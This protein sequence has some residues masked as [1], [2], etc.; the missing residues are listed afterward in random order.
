MGCESWHCTKKKTGC[1]GK[2]WLRKNSND[3]YEV[4]EGTFTSHSKTCLTNGFKKDKRD[5][6]VFL[7]KNLQSF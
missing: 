3:V 2:V 7:R 6:S 5:V 4:V 1:K